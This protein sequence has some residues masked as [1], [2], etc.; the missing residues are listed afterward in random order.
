MIYAIFLEQRSDGTYQ[1]SVP[2]IP[3]LTR[4]GATHDETL[5]AMREAITSTLTSAELVYL[6]IP[7][8]SVEQTNPWLTTAGMF[9]DDPT[10]EPM[11]AEIYAAR[12]RDAVEDWN[13][14]E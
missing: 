12:D 2:L 5:Q 10:L 6:D 1:A 11:L 9:A 3:G 8:K 14:V 4:T 13:I 7:G